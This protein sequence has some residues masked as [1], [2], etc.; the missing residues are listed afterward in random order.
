MSPV[1]RCE[2][3]ALTAEVYNLDPLGVRLAP[4]RV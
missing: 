2:L 3:S 4:R 1:L